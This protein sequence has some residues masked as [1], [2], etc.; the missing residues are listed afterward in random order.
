MSFRILP[1]L[2]LPILASCVAP[3]NPPPAAPE[4]PAPGAPAVRV[5]PQTPAER[6]PGDWSVAELAPG[7]WSYIS[8]VGSS[9]ALFGTGGPAQVRITC[10]GG[11]ITLA[12]AGSIA[13][14]IPVFLNIRNSFAERRLPILR[15][16]DQMLSVELPARDPLWDQIIFSRGRFLIE[17]TNQTPIIVPTRADVARV[18]EDCRS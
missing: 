9:S 16:S 4:P 15:N 7:D 18:I 1:W 17:G 14:D 5:T 10:I 8:R 6:Y 2:L 12:R 13:T 3:R 11:T